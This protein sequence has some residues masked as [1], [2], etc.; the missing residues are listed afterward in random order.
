MCLLSL[1]EICE[2]VVELS[3]TQVKTNIGGGTTD[4]KPE[5]PQ[6][7]SGD[8]ML[9][10]VCCFKTKDVHSFVPHTYTTLRDTITFTISCIS[11]LS[12]DKASQ[13]S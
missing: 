7:L 12:A 8:T 5:N 11:T 2:N 9:E 6:L 3:F 4:M 1:N 10:A 13:G